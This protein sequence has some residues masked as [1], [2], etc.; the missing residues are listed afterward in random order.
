MKEYEFELHLI[1][2]TMPPG[3]NPTINELDDHLD[4]IADKIY[5]VGL[6]YVTVSSQGLHITVSFEHKSSDHWVEVSEKL[7]KI[8]LLVRNIEIKPVQ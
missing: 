3:S 5:E 4:N 8:G 6:D 7:N 1:D 2:K